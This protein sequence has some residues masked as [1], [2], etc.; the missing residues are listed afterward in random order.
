[1]VQDAVLR[2]LQTL[3]EGTS[4]LS[5]VSRALHPEI[6]WRVIYGFRNVLTHD[7]LGINLELVWP[8]VDERLPELK[9]AIIA[10]RSTYR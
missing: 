6:P 8:V 7:Y 5:D 4:R 9:E 10:I 2:N 1:M 3:S